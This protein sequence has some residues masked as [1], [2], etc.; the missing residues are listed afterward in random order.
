MT[1]DEV[2]RCKALAGRGRAGIFLCLDGAC[3]THLSHDFE[4]GWHMLVPNYSHTPFYHSTTSP[5]LASPYFTDSSLSSF[6]SPQPKSLRLDARSCLS[7][8]TSLRSAKWVTPCYHRF[9]YS[10][11]GQQSS[12]FMLWGAQVFVTSGLENLYP[13]NTSLRPLSI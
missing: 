1:R 5:W 10:F 7:E 2:E 4:L 6:I 11:G 8:L 13:R 12:P 3:S 9:L